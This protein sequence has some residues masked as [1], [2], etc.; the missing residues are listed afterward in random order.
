MHNR[1]VRVACRLDSLCQGAQ[2]VVIKLQPEAG[3]GNV[4]MLL[5]RNGSLESGESLPSPIHLQHCTACSP[6][7]LAALKLPHTHPMP[8]WIS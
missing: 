4:H 2:L 6:A 8:S 5:E 1:A 7:Q 3:Q